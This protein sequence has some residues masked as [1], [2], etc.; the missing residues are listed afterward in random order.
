MKT[1]NKIDFRQVL[2]TKTIIPIK[3]YDLSGQVDVKIV[4]KVNIVDII[5]KTQ[6]GSIKP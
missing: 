4:D 3:I 5:R 1:S 2:P 6:D